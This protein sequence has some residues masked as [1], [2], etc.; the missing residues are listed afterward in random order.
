M[1]LRDFALSNKIR[2][3]LYFLVLPL[4][5]FLKAGMETPL[6]EITPI[7]ADSGSSYASISGVTQMPRGSFPT[8]WDECADSTAICQTVFSDSFAGFGIPLA[9]LLFIVSYYISFGFL[10]FAGISLV[11]GISF[12]YLKQVKIFLLLSI[13]MGYSL[14]YF[15][16]AG[17][18]G[19]QDGY[20]L[21]RQLF[22]ADWLIIYSAAILFIRLIFIRRRSGD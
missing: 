18:S 21:S 14:F 20:T 4:P 6:F 8:L 5:W 11:K 16:I 7:S 12:K 2:I 19:L 9:R 3:F 22:P 1:N 15:S 17:N 10:F 13:L